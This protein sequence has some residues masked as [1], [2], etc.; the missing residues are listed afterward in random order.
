MCCSSWSS[1]T[2]GSA[3]YCDVTLTTTS[4]SFKILLL[5]WRNP[6][7]PERA[8]R[9]CI[10]LC[11][12]CLLTMLGVRACS[13]CLFCAVSCCVFHSFGTVTFTVTSLCL[14]FALT[15][16]RFLSRSFA[17]SRSLTVCL[18]PPLCLLFLSLSLPHTHSR[19][20]IREREGGSMRETVSF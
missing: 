9:W 11:I 5:R 15:F 10:S 7:K 20:R 3:S 13:R 12:S 4:D 17:F 1:A 8:T 19:R 16:T 2:D 14:F 6:W 18:C